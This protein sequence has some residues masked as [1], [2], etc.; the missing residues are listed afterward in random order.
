MLATAVSEC[1]RL[2]AI[3]GNV[4]A[5]DIR[6]LVTVCTAAYSSPGAVED[7]LCTV[8]HICRSS[9]LNSRTCEVAG[10]IPAVLGAMSAHASACASVAACGC[11][12]LACL[13]AGAGG[14]IN[15]NSIVLVGGGL[16]VLFTVMRGHPGDEDLQRAACRALCFT[17]RAVSPGGLNVMRNS[18]AMQLIHDAKRTHSF[19][20]FDTVK[21]WAD[22]A[23]AKLS[24]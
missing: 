4:P 2:C 13:V 3:R 17:A 9:F 20:G 6:T 8:A 22:L 1:E 24:V 23:L 5:D 21:H 18:D 15:A 19:T 14:T 16:D 12:A 10:V 7:F 11:E